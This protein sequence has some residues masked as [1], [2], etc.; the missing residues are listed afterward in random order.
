M[1]WESEDSQTTGKK[2]ENAE[3][4][5]Y[6]AEQQCA[7]FSLERSRW[8]CEDRSINAQAV[9]FTLTM[10]RMQEAGATPGTI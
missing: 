6:A 9:N 3:D 8:L 7:V 2:L 1:Q 10:G 5:R 4:V